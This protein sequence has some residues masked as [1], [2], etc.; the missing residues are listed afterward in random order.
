MLPGMQPLPRGERITPLF[1]RQQGTHAAPIIKM[2]P[3][4]PAGRVRVRSN[5]SSRHGAGAARAAVTHYGAVM[6]LPKA[7]LATAAG[8]P[9]VARDLAYT[10]LADIQLSV[11]RFLRF[12]SAR[13][14]QQFFV[15][16][17]G[18]GLA[19]YED[20]EVAPMFKLAPPNCSLP[21]PW[22]PFTGD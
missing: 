16:L 14:E 6:A 15:T 20:R 5:L 8:I 17:I 11:E 12:A 1:A 7:L 2:A 21:L 10:P 13:P 9:T 3:R 18:C 4:A 22:R 19:G